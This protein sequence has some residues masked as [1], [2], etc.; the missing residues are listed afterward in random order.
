V[1]PL[2]TIA[3]RVPQNLNAILSL[4]RD[5]KIDAISFTS[6]SAVRQFYRLFPVA[7]WLGLA[8]APLLCAIGDTTAA[9]LEELGMRPDV[10]P[11]QAEGE[12][13]IAALGAALA[14]QS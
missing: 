6:P 4:L 3:P 2:Y 10:V 11:A 9:A 7:D 14:S 12:G 8:R 1:L 5:K 13:M